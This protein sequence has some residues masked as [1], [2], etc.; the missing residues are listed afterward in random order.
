MIAALLIEHPS[1]E[2]LARQTAEHLAQFGVKSEV[3]LASAFKTPDAV[4]SIVDDLNQTEDARVMICISDQNALPGITAANSV[5]PVIHLYPGS[6]NPVFTPDESPAT[7][8][9]SPYNAALCALRMLALT[10]RKLRKVMAD[11]INSIREQ[12]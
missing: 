3:Y 7:I 5:F 9:A 10:D 2:S 12:L 11:H 8:V 1:F 6:G 4:L